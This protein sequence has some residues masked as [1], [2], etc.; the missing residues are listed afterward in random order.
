MRDP[1]T[2]D[3][4]VWQRALFA[5][6][7]FALVA[8]ANG[9]GADFD[10]SAWLVETRVLAVEAAPLDVVGDG[11]VALVATVFV[12]DGAAV[13]REQWRVCPLSKGPHAAY[14][15]VAEA[16]EVTLAPDGDG[17]VRTRP[18]PLLLAC[19][20]RLEAGA[21]QGGEAPSGFDPDDLPASVEIVYEHEVEDDSGLIRESVLRL[22]LWLEGEPDDPN[23]APVIAAVAVGGATVAGG[24]SVAPVAEGEALTI[25]VQVD[26][27]SLDPYTDVDGSALVEEPIVSFFAT[28]GRFE[29]EKK[30][31]ADVETEWKAKA[32]EDGEE[33]ASLWVVVHDL[34]GGQAVAGPFHVPIRR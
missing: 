27:D 33:R 14:E 12:P 3:R 11:E 7:G 30:T 20:A 21:G 23:T 29:R 24:D 19:V 28:A 17:V 6:A 13:V 8:L 32:L 15:C 26:P 31:G 10:P 4:S 22:P 25:R 9:C 2:D 18:L 1:R 34:R 16:C 5:A